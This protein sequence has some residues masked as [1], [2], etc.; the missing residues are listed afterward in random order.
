[1]IAFQ[2]GNAYLSKWSNLHLKCFA[3]CDEPWP[4]ITDPCLRFKRWQGS[5]ARNTTRNYSVPQRR[6]RKLEGKKRIN[7]EIEV[8]V[9]HNTSMETVL[10][11]KKLNSAGDPGG[12]LRKEIKFIFCS[13]LLSLW[14]YNRTCNNQ[15]RHCPLC[16]R[17]SWW[18][19]VMRS[20]TEDRTDSVW[21]SWTVALCSRS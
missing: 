14:I 13:T 17:I 7:V 6:I 1:M 12:P 4:Q 2:Y 3:D 15:P 8:S 10:R 21:W 11:N 16:G 18:I 20:R 5:G 9:Y 19:V